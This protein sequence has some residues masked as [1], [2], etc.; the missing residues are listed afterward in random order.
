MPAYLSITRADLAA[1]SCGSFVGIQFASEFPQKV[2]RLWFPADSLPK[3]AFHAN[4]TVIR[5]SSTGELT[6]WLD[7]L[8]GEIGST[9]AVGEGWF[10]G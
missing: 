7:S 5:M 8:E 3:E 9:G 6:M 10:C 4:A 2:R 1:Q